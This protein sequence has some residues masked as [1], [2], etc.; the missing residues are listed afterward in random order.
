MRKRRGGAARAAS[1]GAGR[2]GEAEAGEISGMHCHLR[3]ARRHHARQARAHSSKT[4]A[5][6]CFFG[7]ASPHLALFGPKGALPPL[8]SGNVSS[9][10]TTRANSPPAAA[11][12]SRTS[13]AGCGTRAG[14]GKSQERPLPPPPPPRCET[15]RVPPLT[16]RAVLVSPQERLARRRLRCERRLPSACGGV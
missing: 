7:S 9:R 1:G 11:V 5:A 10:A 13:S 8:P 4:R 12:P 14:I 3:L 2:C 16:T 6:A 15:P